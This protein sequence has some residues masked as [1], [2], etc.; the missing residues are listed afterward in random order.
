MVFFEL[1]TKPTRKWQCRHEIVENKTLDFK[2]LVLEPVAKQTDVRHVLLFK[3]HATS[4]FSFTDNFGLDRLANQHGITWYVMEYNKECYDRSVKLGQTKS[5]NCIDHFVLCADYIVNQIV[6]GGNVPIL[7]G[8]SLGSAMLLEYASRA[9]NPRFHKIVLM[10]P[11]LSLRDYFKQSVCFLLFFGK[12]I[13]RNFSF[14]NKRNIERASDKLAHLT[15]KDNILKNRNSILIIHGNLDGVIPAWHSRE[16]A[17]IGH[18]E[19]VEVPWC[20]HVDV[21]NDFF[22]WT[23]I[24]EFIGPR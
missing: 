24:L 4:I 14:N 9:K 12:R 21:F 6:S 18:C 3:S 23:K 5:K 17:R 15:V 8:F 16:L 11:F 20:K 19:L 2:Y 22:S 13:D 10:A 7:L 1:V